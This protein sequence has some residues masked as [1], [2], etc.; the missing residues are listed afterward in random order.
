MGHSS[1][2]SVAIGEAGLGPRRKPGFPARASGES[3]E[4]LRKFHETAR[5]RGV[6]GAFAMPRAIA[7]KPRPM[8][9]PLLQLRDIRLTFGGAPLLDGAELVVAPG[10]R[11]ALVGRNGSGKSTL[12]KIAAGIVEADAGERFA[13]SGATIRYL[14]QEPDLTG[15]AT[16]LDYVRGGLAPGDD[17]HRALYLLNELGLTGDETPGRLSGGEQRRAAL[18]R[19]LAPDRHRR[20]S[21]TDLPWRSA[22]SGFFQKP[23]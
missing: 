6:A 19:V 4:V 8:A 1:C 14:P 11:V 2:Q 23:R 22:G 15:F 10:D 7:H 3:S 17:D 20:S 13:D 21:A 5:D 18:A 16:V 9:A 12:L